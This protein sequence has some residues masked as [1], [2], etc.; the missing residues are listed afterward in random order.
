MN[1]IRENLAQAANR[2][3]AL[4]E[5][6]T[7][8]ADDGGNDMRN[9][10]CA[11]AQT[12]LEAARL[13]NEFVAGFDNGQLSTRDAALI[14]CGQMVSDSL[15]LYQTV[16]NNADAVGGDLPATKLN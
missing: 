14:Q 8:L 5:H 1:A 15:A 4:A 2:Y 9:A 12:Y 7:R 10:R 6:F 13:L 11:L 3:V 16:M